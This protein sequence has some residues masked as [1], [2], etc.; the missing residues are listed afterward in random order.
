[1][2]QRIPRTDEFRVRFPVAPLRLRRALVVHDFA[3]LL[4]SKYVLYLHPKE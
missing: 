3:G 4:N 1:M 2:G